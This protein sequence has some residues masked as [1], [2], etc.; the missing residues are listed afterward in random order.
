MPPY[1]IRVSSLKGGVG[2]TTI[3]TNLA[4]M[5]QMRGH[6]TLLVDCD[7]TNPSVGFFLGMETSNIGIISWLKSQAQ[8]DEVV[9]V[10]SASGL[11]V[12]NGQIDMD[13]YLPD[14]RMITRMLNEL[15]KSN[16]E[17]IIIDTRPGYD[18]I[19]SWRSIS[20][21]LIV[22]LPEVPSYSGTIRSAKDFDKTGIKH[23][24]VVNRIKNSKYEIQIDEINETYENKIVGAFP[25]DPIIPRSVSEKIP[26]VL[27][28]QNSKFSVQMLRL[29]NIYAPNNFFYPRI[30]ESF[31][32]IIRRIINSFRKPKA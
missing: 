16:Y 12:I 32:D 9:A 21:A 22:T 27:L 3:A 1:I 29:S 6:R 17:F 2:K 7:T 5:L 30:Y 25:E 8:L 20:E 4:V 31:M 10:H 23:K 15:G 26:A 11:R 28:D 18:G 13:P 19:T 24:L 14:P